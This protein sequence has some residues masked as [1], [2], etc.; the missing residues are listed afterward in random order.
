MTKAPAPEGTH[1]YETR[2]VAFRPVIVASL[3]VIALVVGTLVAMSFLEAGLATRE[4]ERSAPASP[5]A[6]TYGRREPPAPRLQ[7]APA[8]DLAALRAREAALLDGYAWIDRERGRVR[9]PVTRAMELLT[10]TDR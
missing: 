9:V 3:A 10:E 5:L 1:A 8:K 2:D 7:D 4:T 6:A